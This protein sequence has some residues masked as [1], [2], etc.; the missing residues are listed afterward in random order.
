MPDRKATKSTKTGRSQ[1]SVKHS[2]RKKN[3]ETLMHV[4]RSHG[5]FVGALGLFVAV[6]LFALFSFWSSTNDYVNHLYASVNDSVVVDG[7]KM[8]EEVKEVVEIFTDVSSKHINGGAI[9]AL[10]NKGIIK[11][12]TDGGF[13]PDNTINRAEF[14]VVVTNA[15]DSDFGGL[16]LGD[17]CTDV[18]D[19]WYSTFMCYGKQEGWIKGYEDGSCRPESSVTRAEAIKIAYEAMNFEVC[20]NVEE[21]PFSDVALDDWFAPYACAAKEGGVIPRAGQFN[22][23]TALTRAQVSQIVFNMLDL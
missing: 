1:A 22:G 3:Y 18:S 11:G 8:G 9:E 10:Y 2:F 19:E 21:A 7:M 15:V 23:N 16:T 20:G 12:Y 5:H 13:H 14:M 4:M 17:C 6:S